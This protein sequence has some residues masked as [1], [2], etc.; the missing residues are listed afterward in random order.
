MRSILGTPSLRASGYD[1]ECEVYALVLEKLG[2]SLED[3]LDMI[4]A[5]RFDERMVLAV[6]IQMLD[7]YA[8][9]HSV[10]VIHNGVKPGN[11][12]LSASTQR[13]TELHLIDFGLSYFSD[14]ETDTP[15]PSAHR[16]DTVGNRQFLSILGHHGITQSQRDDL[17]SLGYLLSFL[18]HGYLP[19][20]PPVGKQVVKRSRTRVLST[21]PVP[22]VWR[23]KMSTPGSVLFRDMDPSFLGFW[24]DVK[25]LAFGEKSD[26]AFLKSRFVEC[27]T[28]RGFRGSPGEID[29]LALF[30]DLQLIQQHRLRQTALMYRLPMSPTTIADPVSVV[31]AH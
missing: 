29:W 1:D 19:W 25:S 18:Y 14:L 15:L 27:W 16:A 6:A 24:K 9:L 12:C 21:S 31:L 30:R 4:P 28:R 13:S 22:Q 20:D 5:R 10:G 3:F 2:P 11:I 7:R 8:S 23:V 17:E 26:Y